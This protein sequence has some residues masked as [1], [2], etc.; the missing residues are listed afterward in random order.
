MKKFAL[1]IALLAAPSLA[2]AQGCTGTGGINSIDACQAAVSIQLT[3]EVAT[4]QLG[5]SPHTRKATWT[6]IGALIGGGATAVGGDLTGTVASATVA[7]IN[8][9]TLGSTTAT[10]A[11]VLIGSGSA[12]V[13]HA[14]SGDWTI[15][16]T[17]AATLATVNAN[18]GTWGDSTHTGQFTVNGKGLITAVSSVAIAAG[19]S[20]SV[21]NTWTAAQRGQPSTLVI[22]TATFTPNF[23]TAQNFAMTLIHASCVCVVANPSTTPVAG[24][25]GM[26]AITQSATGSDTV[27]WGGLYKF[28]GATAPTLSTGANA[29]DFLP[30]YVFSA[31]QIVVGAGVLNAH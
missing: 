27:T 9:A 8:G 15:S 21:A 1:L 28:A 5:Q 11:N 2:W 10:S 7:K 12:W 17:G 4:Y 3:D 16:N 19:V 30:Y 18:T 26:I 20:L 6:Q 25:S 22:S 29:V 23:D 13:T 31:T 24:Q 14:F